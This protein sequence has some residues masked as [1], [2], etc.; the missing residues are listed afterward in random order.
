MAQELFFEVR[1]QKLHMYLD[2]EEGQTVMDLKRMVAGITSDPVQN[3]ELWK[4]DEDGKKS[5]VLHDTA[6]LV[7]CGYSSTNAKAQS[8]AALGLRL[9]GAE[10]HLEIHDVSTPPPI[11]D[12]M[13]AEPAP[14]D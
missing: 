6:T 14:Q 2:A 5:Q 8:P 9:V 7:D 12:T 4:L 3:M 1:R 13:R 10:E 11:P